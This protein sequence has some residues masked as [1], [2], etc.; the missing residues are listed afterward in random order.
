MILFPVIDRFPCSV[1]F[2]QNAKA[3]IT[4]KRWEPDEKRLQNRIGNRSRPIEW[5][6]YF[7]YAAPPS[8]GFLFRSVFTASKSAINSRTV[9]GRREM[10]T[11]HEKQIEVGISNGQATSAKRRLLAPI[12]ASS[13]FWRL[14]KALITRKWQELDEECFVQQQQQIHVDLS[15]GH[16]TSLGVAIFSRFPLPMEFRL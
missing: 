11:E 14:L 8:A 16:V 7:R 6:S 13:P 5:P 15:D 2:F 9:R 10:F 3:L 12:S 1:R 4:R